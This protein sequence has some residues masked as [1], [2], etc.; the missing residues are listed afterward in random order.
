MAKTRLGEKQPSSLGEI[1]DLPI[2][3]SLSL[4]S[5]TSVYDLAS[6]SMMHYSLNGQ[7]GLLHIKNSA[8][9]FHD[10]VQGLTDLPADTLTM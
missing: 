5:D 7:A 9:F 4:S 2:L 1:L 3:I 8:V 6:D 10:L